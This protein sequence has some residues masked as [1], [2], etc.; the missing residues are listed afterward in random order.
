MKKLSIPIKELREKP[1]NYMNQ[2]EDW[3]ARLS[4][5]EQF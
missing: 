5:T 4:D 2:A 1:Y 3:I